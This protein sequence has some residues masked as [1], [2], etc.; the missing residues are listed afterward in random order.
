MTVITSVYG[1]SDRAVCV[2]FLGPIVNRPICCTSF[3]VYSTS[4]AKR[5]RSVMVCVQYSALLWK[6]FHNLTSREKNKVISV[7]CLA[8]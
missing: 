8:P 6:V 7:K 4:V 2:A 3:M 5:R 1:F